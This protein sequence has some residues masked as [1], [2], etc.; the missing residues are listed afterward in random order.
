MVFKFFSFLFV[1]LIIIC[2]IFCNYVHIMLELYVER[3][4]GT[5]V[6]TRYEFNN[7]PIKNMF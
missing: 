4:E 5:N 2:A 6:K 1:S 7:D 3:V